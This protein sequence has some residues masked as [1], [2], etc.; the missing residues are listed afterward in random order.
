M[1]QESFRKSL[2]D[3]IL[4]GHAYLHV[5]STEKIR[6]LTE[7]KEMAASLPDDGRPVFV[8]S[9]ATGWRDGDGNRATSASGQEFGQPDPQKI[10]QEILDLPEGAIFVLKD[11]STLVF[12]PTWETTLSGFPSMP[13]SESSE[14]T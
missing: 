7:L 12:G 9:Q 3:Y 4:S 14:A 5:R 8:W 11:H 13:V 10:A 2:S 6:F 1:E